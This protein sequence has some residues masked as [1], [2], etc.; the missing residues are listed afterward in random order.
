MA[1]KLILVN[2]VW[3]PVS[4]DVLSAM[5]ALMATKPDGSMLF[6]LPANI[7]LKAIADQQNSVAGIVQTDAEVTAQKAVSQ[8]AGGFVVDVRGVIWRWNGTIW[9]STTLTPAALGILL[10]PRRMYYN[11][12][13]K[14]VWYVKSDMTLLAFMKKDNPFATQTEVTNGQGTGLVSPATL[15]NAFGSW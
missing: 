6:G 8:V 10:R 9:T 4:D 1:K 3:V 13:T 15:K 12:L 11:T 5:T 14:V 7:P 2:G